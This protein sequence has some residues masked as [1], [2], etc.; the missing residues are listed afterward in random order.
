MTPTVP[1]AVINARPDPPPA[2]VVAP[3]A[4]AAPS[5]ADLA[6]L[7]TKIAGL[8]AAV[9]E[10]Q[11]VAQFWHDKASAAPAAPAKAPVEE[12]ETDMLDLLTTGGEK[13]LTKLLKDRGF[14]STDQAEHM[15]EGRVSQ[16]RS[17]QQLIQ[18]YPELS[19]SDSEFFKATAANYGK[20]T[21]AGVAPAVAS[22]LAAEQA[23]LQGIRAGKI[24]TPAQKTAAAAAAK[25]ADRAARAAAG[26]GER[27]SRFQEADPED[28]AL[29]ENDNAA[30]RNLA[31][32]LDIPLKDAETRYIARAKAGVNVALKLDRGRR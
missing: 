12:P 5:A 21:K 14:L 23:E 6:A 20:L 4:P 13:A 30:I 32:A 25:A 24:L 27:G 8:Q 3:A 1:P 28:D 22:R 26:A 7:N 29:S 2:A 31:E 16:V 18:E 11:Q 10:Q 15:I 17:E 19:D 9:T